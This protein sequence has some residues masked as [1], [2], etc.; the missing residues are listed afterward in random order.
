MAGE[1]AAGEGGGSAGDHDGFDGDVLGGGGGRRSDF[2]SIR[3]NELIADPSGGAAS[4]GADV[5]LAGESEQPAAEG[6]PAWGLEI[7]A[8]WRRRSAVQPEGGYWGAA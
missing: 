5:L 7:R 1:A 3:R 8:G 4:G 6:D 2:S